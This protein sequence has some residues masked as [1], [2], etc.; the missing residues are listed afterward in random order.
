MNFVTRVFLMSLL[1]AGLA[2]TSA[3]NGK[4]KQSDE[5]KSTMTEEE[6]DKAG[7]ARMEKGIDDL[8]GEA[9]CGE[10]GDCRA[11]A[12]GAKPCG[13]PWKFK[14]YAA[15]GVDEAKLETMVAKYN[16]T[17]EALNE[18]HGWMSDCLAVMPPELECRDG[19]CVAV[20][21]M[22]VKPVE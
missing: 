19:R 2:A 15:S 3:C 4:N 20:D 22:K 14:V 5:V 13:G 10:P 8:I 7:L 21:N 9:A 17:N 18:K 6:A 12:F 16:E 11:I 1:A